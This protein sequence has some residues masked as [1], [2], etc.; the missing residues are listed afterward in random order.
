MA[1]SP[2]DKVAVGDPLVVLESMKMETA[3]KASFPGRV[4]SVAVAPNVQ[5]DTGDPL[6]QLEPVIVEGESAPGAAVD[7]EFGTPHAS[8]ADDAFEALRAGT[9]SA[10]TWTRR[11]FD[12]SSI[13]D[14]PWD[15][16][17]ADDPERLRGEEEILQLFADVCAVSR[18]HPEP[19]EEVP[20]E[21]VRAPEEHLLTCLRTYETGAEGVPPVFFDH[22]LGVLRHHGIEGLAPSTD[23]E[24]ALLRLYRSQQRLDELLPAVGAILDRRL[25]YREELTDLAGDDLHALLDH[26]VVATDGRYPGLMDLARDVRFRFFEQPVLARAQAELYA[27]MDRHVEALAAGTD[28]DEQARRM[29]ALIEC[30]LPMRPALLRWYQQR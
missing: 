8:Q 3:V 22:L 6:V 29:K 16:L 1:V 13:G 11:R 30:P 4:R 10:T 19:A 18:R 14:D 5:V 20:G 21:R 24:D 23:V 2:G 25:A 12:G 15:S 28:P 17:A 27:E 7:L 26:L 9:S